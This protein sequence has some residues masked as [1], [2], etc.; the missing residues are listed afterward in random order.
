MIGRIETFFRHLRRR[1]S[2]SVWL[3]RLLRLPVSEGSPTRPGLLMIQID[4]LSQS[5]FEH[6]L[7]RNE[8]PFLRRL[9]TREHYRLQAHYSGLPSTTPA[10]RTLLWCQGRWPG[11]L[12]QGP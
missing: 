1:L 5:Q 10:V 3:T 7:A 12:L 6:A 4:G 11:I 2:R 9:I 8:L